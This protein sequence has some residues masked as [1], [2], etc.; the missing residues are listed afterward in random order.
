MSKLTE[1]ARKAIDDRIDEKVKDLNEAIYLIN[2]FK[3]VV[4]ILF[5]ALGIGS[6]WGFNDL[7]KREVN[8]RISAYDDFMG[9]H[10]LV[11][12]DNYDKSYNDLPN[13]WEKIK[14][15]SSINYVYYS[16]MI[17]ILSSM[18]EYFNHSFKGQGNWNKLNKDDDFLMFIE[19]ELPKMSYYDIINLQLCKL[20]FGNNT[21]VKEAFASI[22]EISNN[23]DTTISLGTNNYVDR[24][25]FPFIINIIQKDE[26]NVAKYRK[27]LLDYQGNFFSRWKINGK[28]N[29]ND[30]NLMYWANINHK[31]NNENYSAFKKRLEK[32]FN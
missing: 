9:A 15:K 20:K 23:E 30:I 32:Y 2:T 25:W 3:W 26:K 22:E 11:R 21:Q 8:N 5:I 16:D 7:I 18:T 19:N 17:K 14:K 28:V 29:M 6:I 13:T 10:L 24:F 12:M 4:G 31:I 27:A 1:E